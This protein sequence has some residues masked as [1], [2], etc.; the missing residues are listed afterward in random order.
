MKT[1]IE[2]INETVEFYSTVS[3]RSVNE[4]KSCLY[5]G[6]NGKKC[7]FSRCLKPE[8]TSKDIS[9]GVEIEK[10]IVDGHK[11]DDYLKEEYKGHTIHFWNDIQ[12]LHDD[13]NNWNEDSGLSKLGIITVKILREVHK[14]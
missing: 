1:K 4:N 12:A 9:E 13:G 5:F 14:N 8:I 7:A 2:I 6:T 10:C 3:N 11:Y